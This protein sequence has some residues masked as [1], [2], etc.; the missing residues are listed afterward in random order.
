MLNPA[1]TLIDRAKNIYHSDQQLVHLWTRFTRKIQRNNLVLGLIPGVVI[2]KILGWHITNKISHYKSQAFFLSIA[3]SSAT[4][5]DVAFKRLKDFRHNTRYF[6]F[7]GLVS[8]AALFVAYRNRVKK[9]MDPEKLFCILTI[10]N[11]EASLRQEA[12]VFD[13]IP[14]NLQPQAREHEAEQSVQDQSTI[15]SRQRDIQGY[16]T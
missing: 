13:N 16:Y 9:D 6:S 1:E 14:P 10:L 15:D 4:V 3:S 12:G 7:V 8:V 11:K 5:G 2:K